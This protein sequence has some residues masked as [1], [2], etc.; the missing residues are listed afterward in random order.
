ML[1]LQ[2]VFPKTLETTEKPTIGFI[3]MLWRTWFVLS[4]L[5]GHEAISEVGHF[6]V[7]LPFIFA[8]SPSFPYILSISSKISC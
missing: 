8:S 6:E 2:E 7:D 3:G 4:K 5:S 1:N